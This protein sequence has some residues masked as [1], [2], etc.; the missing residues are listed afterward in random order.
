MKA[1]VAALFVCAALLSATSSAQS[2]PEPTEAQIDA[3]F[4]KA[5]PDGNGTLSW[6]EA[7][8]FGITR[9]A[10]EKANPDK[11]GSLDKKEFLAAVKIR[12]EQAN[13]DNDGTL[14]RKEAARA[15]IKSRKVFEAAN[16]DNDGTLDLAEYLD[17][18]TLQAK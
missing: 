9:A 17:A 5:D 13:P 3:A 18:L 7:R 1:P 15:G 12:F 6:A 14:D 10:F 11:D 2:A 4:K 8:R 16:P